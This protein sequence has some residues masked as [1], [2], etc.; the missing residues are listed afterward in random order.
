VIDLGRAPAAIGPVIGSI[1]AIATRAVTGA[2]D[3]PRVVVPTTPPGIRPGIGAMSA[4]QVTVPGNSVLFGFFI[5]LTCALSFAEERRTGTGR[6]L[7]AAPVARWKLLFAKLLPYIALG[8]AQVGILFVI[9]AAGF[10][11]EVGGSVLA[12]AVMT[13][14]VACCAAGLGLLIASVSSTE[15]QISSLGSLVVLIMGLL[16]GCMIPRELMPEALRSAGL[17]VPQ[18]WALDAYHMLLARAGT[19]IFDVLP[20][21]GAVYGFALLFAV[22]GMWR[23]K[24]EP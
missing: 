17:F 21:I 6:R 24:F 18:A 1:S 4:F 3:P 13:I 20:Q 12:L 2:G 10:G 11:M 15:K 5:A 22:V 14:G 7:L 16:G 9:G 19:T 8:A 23:F